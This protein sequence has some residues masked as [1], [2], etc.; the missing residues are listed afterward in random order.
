[1]LERWRKNWP[2]L[3]VG[4]LLACFFAAVVYAQGVGTFAMSEIPQ[5]VWVALIAG[6]VQ[7]LIWYG[8]VNSKLNSLAERMRSLENE[9]REDN[10]TFESR[11]ESLIK[12]LI[13]TV[14]GS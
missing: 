10:R 13:N 4:F 1:M 8:A 11:Y 7:G 3:F 6:G 12:I 14:K 5:Y 2:Y 9:R